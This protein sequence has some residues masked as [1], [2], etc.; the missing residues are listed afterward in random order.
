M[1][2]LP[3]RPLSFPLF[4][5]LNIPLRACVLALATTG[6]FFST[7]QA[8]TPSGDATYQQVCAACHASGVAGAPKAGDRKT[9][10]KLIAEGQTVLTAHGYVGVRGMPARGGKADLTLEAFAAAVVHMANQAGASWKAPDERQLQ[11][12]RQEIEKR[13]KQLAAKATKKP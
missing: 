6:A 13:E 4:R 8:Q 9:W 1:S 11:A 5:R 2:L 10:S 3:Q 12:I 7:V